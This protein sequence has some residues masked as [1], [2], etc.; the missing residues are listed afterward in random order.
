MNY[1][2]LHG[3]ASGPQSVKAVDLQ[4]RFAERGINLEV[5]DLNQPDFFNLTLTR[6]IRQCEA[7][8][9]ADKRDWTILGS[10]LGGL[11]AAWLAQRNVNV[12]RL[13]LLAPAF[14]FL[15]YWQQ[16]LGAAQLEQWRKDGSIEVYHYVEVRSLPLGYSFWADASQ[17]SEAELKQP[18]PTLI[19]HGLF[20]EVIP[21]EAS[22]RYTAQ[23]PWCTLIELQSDHGLTDRLPKIWEATCRF[24]EL[25]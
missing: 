25:V 14:E 24:C 13:V 3:F 9:A 19:L 10:S 15:A 20:D 5:P 4:N 17:Y 22:R 8:L 6:Q 11:T 18:T 12:H 7:I 2:Y 23:R 16:Q 1:L 21:I